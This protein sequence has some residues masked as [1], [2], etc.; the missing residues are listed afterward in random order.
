MTLEVAHP[1][2]TWV[3][4][5]LLGGNEGDRGKFC[6]IFPRDW[7]PAVP[8]HTQVLNVLITLMGIIK[9]KYSLN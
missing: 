6:C 8:G 2:G 7:Q 3:V 1:E 9:V 5:P 4:E